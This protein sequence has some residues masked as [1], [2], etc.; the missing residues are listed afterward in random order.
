MNDL[1]QTVII[2][3]GILFGVALTLWIIRQ[4]RS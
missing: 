3:V 4:V 2:V 1:E